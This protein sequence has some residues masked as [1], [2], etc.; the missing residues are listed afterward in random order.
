MENGRVIA[1][2]IDIDLRSESPV[3]IQLRTQVPQILLWFSMV[4]RSP[5]DLQFDRMILT[6][7]VNQPLIYQAAILSRQPLLR[8]ERK[9][10]IYFAGHFG[11]SQAAEITRLTT[12]QG[13]L[14]VVRLDLTAFF[15]ARDGW[16]EVTRNIQR[17]KVPV[18]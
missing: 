12:P 16:I 17:T 10:T 18:G 7:W 6:L 4:N 9:E 13:F 3:S 5:L 14:D 15:Q 8:G 1:A 11:S 2:Q